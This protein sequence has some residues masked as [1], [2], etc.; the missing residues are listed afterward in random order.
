MDAK[1]KEVFNEL[2][3]VHKEIKKIADNKVKHL[4]L[5]FGQCQLLLM[6]DRCPNMNQKRLA[7][8]LH[9]TE[10]TLSVRISR[11]E[12]SGYIIKSIDSKDKRK[13]SLE[14]SEKGKQFFDK[15]IEMMNTLNETIFEGIS[16]EEL[17]TVLVLLKKMR[18]NIERGG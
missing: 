1:I 5:S 17:D 11:L 13:Y 2:G 16:E 10:A 4:D 7:E 6:I 8:N 18:S 9:I 15:R 14:V 3:I 12:K